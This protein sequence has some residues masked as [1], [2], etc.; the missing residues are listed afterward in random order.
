[1]YEVAH[2]GLVVKN[3]ERSQAFYQDVLGCAFQD[4]HQDERVRL[5]FL[6][7]GSQVIELVEYLQ[8][9]PGERLAGVVDHIAFRVADMDEAL[10]RLREHQVNLLFDAP[11]TVGAK[12]IMFFTGPD[13]ERLEF[14][15]EMR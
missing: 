15:Q 10:R 11:R 12:K 7:A 1:M 6:Q 8:P 2:I 14:I 3:T 5:T 9:P 13:G 4:S